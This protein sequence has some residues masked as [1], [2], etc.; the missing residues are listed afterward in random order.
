MRRKRRY[1]LRKA[2]VFCAALVAFVI[3]FAIVFAVALSAAKPVI[4]LNCTE[5]Q[6]EVF[7]DY[8]KSKVTATAKVLWFNFDLEVST[9]G[10]VDMGKLGEY[11]IKHTAVFSKKSVTKTQ[12]IKVVDTTPPEIKTEEENAV[13]KFESYPIK[14]SDIKVSF[15][16]T[17]N[18][19]GDLTAQVEQSIVND[20]QYFL[21]V[22]DSSGNEA[23][24]E[25]NLIFDDGERPTLVLSGTT[26]VYVA[27]GSKYAEPGYSAMDKLD[28]DITDK[29]EITGDIDF[30]KSGTYLV[31]YKVT[32]SNGYTTKISRKVVVYGGKTADNF[33]DVQPNGKVVY[34]TFDD[35]PGAYTDRL[36][37]YL[38]QYNVK[39]T[40]FVTNQFSKYQDLIG[41]AYS[42]GHKIAVHTYSHQMYTS[43]NNIYSSIDAYMK[44]FNKMQD[45]IEAQTGTTTNIFRFPGGTNNTISKSLCPGIMTELTKQ[46]TAAG[47]FY[48]DWNVDSYDSRSSS[49]TQKIIDETISQI[50]NKKNAVVLMHD[51]HKK[52][53]DAVPAI[54]EYCLENGYTFKVLDETA[55]AV[56]TKPQN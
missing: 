16:A 55:P 47:Y 22:K 4:S 19:D 17:D 33:G 43:S 52:T 27:E 9:V 37:G 21:K 11:E 48:F 3:I 29:V 1:T 15:T 12:K 18:Y 46:M 41:K 36:L 6:L 32:D 2:R 45:V 51:I 8:T 56:R 53:V 24:K 25:I 34:L 13:V 23:A 39:A 42:Q 40:F 26:T 5:E 30:N 38:K 14:L 31:N 35:G 54:I 28:G 10:E 49:N 50:K 7:S 20:N 44:D